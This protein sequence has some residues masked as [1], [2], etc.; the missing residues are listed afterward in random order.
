MDPEINKNSWTET[1]KSFIFHLHKIYSNH[2]SKISKYLPGR[3][4]NAVK[5]FFYSTLRKNLRRD[6][7]KGKKNEQIQKVKSIKRKK[8]KKSEETESISEASA[9][10]ISLSKSKIRVKNSEN[11]DLMNKETVCP[12]FKPNNFRTE[13]IQIPMVF[14]PKPLMNSN[15]FNEYPVLFFN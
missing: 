2:W 15:Q 14:A 11:L 7:T 12:D 1:E 4:D 10:L 3:S 6:K 5:N 8:V 13:P 9:I